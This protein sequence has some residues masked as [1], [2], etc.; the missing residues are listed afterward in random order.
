MKCKEIIGML[1]TLAPLAYQEKWDNCGLLLGDEKKTVHT[2][3]I[4]VDPTS[5]V[6][7]QAI[8]KKV[9]LLI[10]HHPLVF[11]PMKNVRADDFIGRRV[12]DL[13]R[14]GICYYAMHTNF[15]IAAMATHAADRLHLVGARPLEPLSGSEGQGVGR[16][17]YLAEE[18]TVQ[19]LIQ[20]VKKEFG[21]DYVRVAGET[22]RVVS[23]V[24][25]LPG[26][27]D[28]LLEAAIRE[29]VEVYISGDMDHHSGIDGA[30]RGIT[31]IDAGHFG[32]EQIMPDYVR[33]YLQNQMKHQG[34]TSKECLV[35]TAK[36]QDPYKLY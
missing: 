14:H 6:I 9:D 1:E 2:V 35:L 30:E 36:E 17:G 16:T 13:I 34:I 32:T 23:H 28:D 24:G 33:S 26:S 15:D 22:D 5:N 29:G 18:T 27:G 19:S 4:A 11:S 20:L 21:L 25:I 10:T 12:M 3:L 7:E 8:S 31:I